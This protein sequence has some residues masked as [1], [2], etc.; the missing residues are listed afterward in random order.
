MCFIKLTT[1]VALG[2]D[3]NAYWLFGIHWRVHDVKLLAMD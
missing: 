2:V 1:W 3:D